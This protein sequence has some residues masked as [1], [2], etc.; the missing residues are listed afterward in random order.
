MMAVAVLTMR[1]L[2]PACSSPRRGHRAVASKDSWALSRHTCAHYAPTSSSC[3]RGLG[4][5]PLLKDPLS[6]LRRRLSPSACE[7]RV[8]TTSVH[9]RSRAVLRGKLTPFSKDDPAAVG[10]Q[11]SQVPCVL[12]HCHLALLPGLL[13]EP[14]H[15]SRAHT[16]SP[17][18]LCVLAPSRAPAHGR[19]LLPVTVLQRGLPRAKPRGGSGT[20]CCECLRARFQL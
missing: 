15:T 14:A 16:P 9:S 1:A 3:A 12:C 18:Q 11:P 7:A 17:T 2:H 10:R 20:P 6:A 19:H 8:P 13:P 5:R 4:A